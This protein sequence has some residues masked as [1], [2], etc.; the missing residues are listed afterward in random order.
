MPIVKDTIEGTEYSFAPLKL[1]EFRT[2]QK[3]A[4]SRD[5]TIIEGIDFWKPYIESSMR[6]A[7]S[8]PP[9]LEE[10]DLDV[11]NRTLSQLIEGVMKASGVELKKTGEAMPAA[12]SG[13]TSSVGS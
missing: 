13:T 3:Q 2:F 8:Q 10:L 12:T 11:A 7:D 9:D 5:S 1:K 4:I 6:R